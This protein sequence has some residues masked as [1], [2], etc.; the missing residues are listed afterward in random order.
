MKMAGKKPETNSLVNLNREVQDDRGINFL[1][2][3][4]SHNT[5]DKP[6]VLQVA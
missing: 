5:Y 3:D 2:I 6:I 1:E 4:V